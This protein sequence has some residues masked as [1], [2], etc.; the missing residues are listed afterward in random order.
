MTETVA[1][2]V[3]HFADVVLDSARGCLRDLKG[4]EIPLAPKPFNLLVVLARNPGQTMSKDA[5]LDA[6]WPGVHVTED[7]LFQA[8]R[9]ARRAIG[10]E[11]GRLLRSVPRRGYLLD[12][13]V[14]LGTTPPV[15]EAQPASSIPAALAPP[16]D[17]PSLVVLPFQNM[18]GDAEQEYF[19]DGMVEEITTA[20][21][22]IRS[23]FVIARNSAFTYKG[24]AVD[25]RQ[26][27]RELGVRY[28]LQGSV[29]KAGGQ[30][31]IGCQLIEAQIGHTVWAE[32]FD[33]H[34]ADVFALQDQV[35]EAVAGA[36]EP[37]L[38]LAEIERAQHKPTE[39]LDAYDLY[40]QALPHHYANTQQD[41]DQA[42]LLLERALLLDPSFSMAKAFAAF[43]M[44]K[45]GIQGWGEP[46]ERE[47][48]IRLAREALADTRDDPATLRCAAHAI[49]SLA[50]DYD[51]A[52]TAIERAFS[53][54]PNS[55]QV[56][57]SAAWIL[58][59]VA[60][61]DRAIALFERAIRLSPLDPELTYFFSGLGI[62]YLQA[63]RFEDALKAGQ[64]AIPLMP[65]R[66]TGHRVVVTALQSLGRHQE[67][68]AAAIRYMAANPSG[69][70]VFADRISALFT[71]ESFTSRHIAALRGAGLPE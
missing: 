27:G 42:L 7:S 44:E 2:Q 15:A 35:T 63:D 64:M 19:A 70:R 37:S 55:A 20:L 67:A 26:V 29:R 34:V 60:Q 9:E 22:R 38:R 21:S 45:R 17:R 11:A 61:T 8:V 25:I 24:R 28:V 47:T 59:Y 54:N 12:A 32:R 57:G 6:V 18:S 31:R 48:A 33:G 41:S 40:L 65:D 69:A 52:L 43:S 10:D 1:G 53:I 58:T 23:L 36:I 66:A 49:A 16:A 39:N 56:L 51:R 5:L 68:R 3:L 62:A 50:H 30:V 13:A 14:A 71:D 46:G 4:V